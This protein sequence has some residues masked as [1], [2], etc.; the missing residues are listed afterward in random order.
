PLVGTGFLFAIVPKGFLPSEDQG[1]F[2]I[3]T[4]G[5]QGIGFDEMVR[6]QQMV[7]DI[8]AKEPDIAGYSNNLGGFGPGGGGWNQWRASVDLKPRAERTRSVDQI[9]A[10]LRPKL[11]QV[12]GIRAFMVN[13]PPINLGGQQGARSLYQFTLQ[14]TDTAELYQWAPILEAK[15]REIPGIEDVSSDLQIKNP[16]VQVTMDRNKI[17]ALGLTVNQVENA[18]Y[19]AYGT[20]QVSTI[21]APNN[22]YQVILQ[23]APEFQRD[24][25]ALSMLYVRS[26]TGQLVPLNTVASITTGTGPLTVN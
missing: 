5:M 16:Q 13:Q 8:I 21:Y 22:Q 10:D 9:I 12:P 11:A 17:G 7:A 19:N 4:E 3:S 25:S 15:V 24:P 1:R 23:V 18:L 6:H 2:N 20:R 14:D 26:A